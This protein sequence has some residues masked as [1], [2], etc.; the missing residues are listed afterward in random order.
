MSE[1]LAPP[2]AAQRTVTILA[3]EQV[4]HNT[5]KITLEDP[6]LARETR[7]GQFIMVRAGQGIDPLLG[8][9][10]ALF[11]VV[12]DAEHRSTTVELVYLVL[13]RGTTELSRKRPGE[14]LPIWGPLGNGFSSP[15]AD[16]GDVGFVAGGIGFTPFLALGKWWQG[17]A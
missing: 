3:N 10:F 8:R 6:R 11:D 9:P 17:K 12:R 5:F 16:G 13:G 7:P 2:R 15:P 4:A 1:A 14:Q